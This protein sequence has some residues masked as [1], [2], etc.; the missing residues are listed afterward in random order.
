MDMA[1][2]Q[3]AG[4][5][6]AQALDT[7]GVA[8]V[9]GCLTGARLEA[10]QHDIPGAFEYMTQEWDTPF[11]VNGGRAEQR[12]ASD[13][14]FPSHRQLY[15]SPP[16]LGHC[17]AVWDVRQDP[18]VA[19]VFADIHAVP[20]EGLVVSF[21]GVGILPPPENTGVGWQQ[22]GWMHMDTS[23]RK[24]QHC[25]QG[26]VNLF[27]VHPGDA[28]LTALLGSHKL[29]EEA[30]AAFE[31]PLPDKSFNFLKSVDGLKEWYIERG[32]QEVRVLAPAGAVVCWNTRTV[33]SGCNPIVG[34]EH[35][36]WRC[37]VYVCMMPRSS[38]T[39]K[40]LARRVDIWRKGR[41]TGHYAA[42]PHMFPA[43]PRTYGKE[44]KQVSVLARAELTRLGKRL[45]GLP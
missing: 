22:G 40:A 7:Y 39:D 21:D 26:L 36:S 18:A 20:K 44:T 30:A 42:D 37:V 43:T 38:C 12:A 13:F 11:L 5:S 2:A 32:C 17:Q 33:H 45:V 41:M 31:M 6:T 4:M 29:V 28:T 9:P 27:D 25:T 24:P 8:V 23:Y 1:W 16:C 34:R 15:Q 14:L 3:P 19:Q 35:P 10:A